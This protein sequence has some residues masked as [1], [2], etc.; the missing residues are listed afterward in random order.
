MKGI[1]VSSISR[2]LSVLSSTVAAL[3]LAATGAQGAVAQPAEQAEANVFMTTDQAPGWASQNGGTNGG[4]GADAQSTYTVANRQEL[5]AALEN[6]G[7]R[8]KPKIIYVSGTIQGNQAADGTLLGEQDYAPGYDVAKYLSCFGE[9]GTWSD[10]SHEY[11]GQQRRARVTG[12][13]ALKRQSE[14]SIPSNT[15]L[16]GLGEDAG[17]VQSNIMLHLAHNVVLRNLSLE[18]PVDYFSSWDPWDGEDGA[19][20]ARFDAISSVTS[21]NIWVDHVTLGDGRYLDRDAPIGP[22]GAPMNRHDGLFDMKDGTDFVTLSN[23]HLLNH[24][25]TMLIGSGDDNAD[26]DAGRLRVSIIGNYFEGIQE[27]APRVR[28]GQ[29]H[30]ANNYFQGRVNDPDSPVTSTAAG[31]YH[32]FLGLGY[33]SQVFSERNAFDYTGPGADASVAV[34]VWNANNFHDEGSWFNQQPADLDAIAAGQYEQRA[35]QASGD[36]LPDWATKGFSNQLDWTPP[37]GFTAM[38]TASGVKHHAKTATGAGVLEV[39]AP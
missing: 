36:P 25:K 30:V 11:C 29:V 16:V 8:D 34:Y 21:T 19:W 15:T 12:S 33:Q 13:N 3:A 7:E 27:R 6:H 22:N 2:K 20:N 5:M 1:I 23:S 37:Y 26:T 24:D 17:F 28:Y 38:D 9:D 4:A 10:Q 14:I 18:A 31:G 35:A 32:Y 39:A